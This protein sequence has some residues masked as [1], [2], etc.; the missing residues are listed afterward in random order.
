MDKRLSHVFQDSIQEIFAEMTGI[1]LVQQ[2]EIYD[3]DNEI[4]S[5]GVASIL[6]FSGAFK[7]RFLIDMEE[8]VALQAAEYLF[9]SSF[10]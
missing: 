3:D 7:G 9:D 4:S 1:E 8:G 5:L 2:G 10:R 6:N